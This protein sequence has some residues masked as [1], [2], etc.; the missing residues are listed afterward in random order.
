MPFVKWQGVLLK[1]WSVWS[2]PGHYGQLISL[3]FTKGR[4]KK[5][6]CRGGE[7]RVLE[8]LGGS[9][10][11]SNPPKWICWCYKSL[12][13]NKKYVQNSRKS[14]EIQNT[15]NFILFTLLVQRVVQPALTIS[16]LS[17]H[18]LFTGNHLVLRSI[19]KEGLAERASL[20]SNLSQRRFNPICTALQGRR[21]NQ[22]ANEYSLLSSKLSRHKPQFY[23]H[24]ADRC[25]FR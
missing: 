7:C 9:F 24:S 18:C 6:K 14:P 25:S 10:P 5:R 22:S 15:W 1:H 8:Y 19:V 16:K 13:I 11:S 12:K 23:I 21:S 20:Q 3:T 2:L 17:V 4:G